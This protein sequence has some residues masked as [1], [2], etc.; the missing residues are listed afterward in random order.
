MYVVKGDEKTWVGNGTLEPDAI[1]FQRPQNYS[2][3]DNCVDG[4][5]FILYVDCLS[6]AQ[7]SVADADDSRDKSNPFTYALNFTNTSSTAKFTLSR[8][9]GDLTILFSGSRLDRDD[10]ENEPSDVGGSAAIALASPADNA[11]P[12]FTFT[13]G[14]GIAWDGKNGEEWQGY[15]PA[16]SRAESLSWF[17]LWSVLLGC[18]TLS[19]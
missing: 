6:F 16:P 12:H 7:V 14:T 10:E 9:E 8:K 3:D 13:N 15:S 1:D 4:L 19:L 18:V 11:L 2:L 17:T 5:H